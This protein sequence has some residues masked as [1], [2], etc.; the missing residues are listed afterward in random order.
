MND[1]AD[2]G[3]ELAATW[4]PAIAD[5]EPPTLAELMTGSANLADYTAGVFEVSDHCEICNGHGSGTQH[6]SP[7]DPSA[8][9]SR[10]TGKPIL[11]PD[12]RPYKIVPCPACDGRDTA[13]SHMEAQAESGQD[14]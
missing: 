14:R 10:R 11:L 3:A 7:D 8:V 12:G 1:R 13:T 9:R 5:P 2:H 6:V 4:V